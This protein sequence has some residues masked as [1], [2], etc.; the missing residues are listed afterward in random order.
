MAA[1]YLLLLERKKEKWYCIFL[2][3][4]KLIREIQLEQESVFFTAAACGSQTGGLIFLLCQVMLPGRRLFR[5]LRW[6]ETPLPGKG[7]WRIVVLCVQ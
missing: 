2:A 1:V 4:L 3:C 5:P 6:G 7:N